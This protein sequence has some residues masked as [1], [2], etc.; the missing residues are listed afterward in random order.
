[1]S[2]TFAVRPIPRLLA[3]VLASMTLAACG[4]GGGGGGDAGGGGTI[5][6]KSISGRVV[7]G[8]MVG[9]TVQCMQGSTAIATTLSGANGGYA[10]DLPAGQSCDSIESRG[11]LDV[12]VTPT[13]PADDIPRPNLVLRAPVPAGAASVSNLF[14]TPASTLVQALVAGGRASAQGSGWRPSTHARTMSVSRPASV[15]RA[16]GMVP[17]ANCRCSMAPALSQAP[18]APSAVPGRYSSAQCKAASAP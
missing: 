17:S 6:P 4:G 14:V 11:G 8:Y 15:W 5:T 9:A 18:S 16:V 3:V 10:F 1:M 2:R 12:G 7:D 13:N